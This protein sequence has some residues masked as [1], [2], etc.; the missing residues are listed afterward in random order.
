MVLLKNFKRTKPPTPPTNLYQR[1]PEQRLPT[2][3]EPNIGPQSEHDTVHEKS[4]D[5]NPD[6]QLARE[7]QNAVDLPTPESPKSSADTT[8]DTSKRLRRKKGCVGHATRL[9]RP[10]FLPPH[11]R[12]GCVQT[13]KFKSK[14]APG[15][16]E[17]RDG[18][19]SFNYC[20]DCLR[21]HQKIYCDGA[22]DFNNQTC[23]YHEQ[24]YVL[25]CLTRDEADK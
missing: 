9:P 18:W 17:G 22:V 14:T 8:G 1:R 7:L 10:P 3:I 13:T 19:E 25:R 5:I 12:N 24:K 2:P 15:A 20:L 4:K 21:D 16:Q 23:R 6:E 11:L